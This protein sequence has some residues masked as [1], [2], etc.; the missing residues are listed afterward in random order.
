MA[1]MSN[2]MNESV[3]TH[4]FTPKEYQVELLDSAKAKNTIVCSSTSSS[5]AFIVVKLLQEYSWQMRVPYGK[6][7][8][9]I[10]DPQ[11]V[12]IMTCHVK[13]LTDL[14]CTSIEWNSEID[15][16]R[17]EQDF[18]KNQVIIS[19]AE[20]CVDVF[21]YENLL[22]DFSIFNL[23][24]VDDCLYGHRQSLIKLIMNKYKHLSSEK[25]PRI[26]GLTTGLL[27]S[28]LQPDRL[29][30]EL[31]RLEKLLDSHVDTS[32]EIVTLIRLS[33]RPHECII[34]CPGWEGHD[35]EEYIKTIVT[36]TIE[37][38][39]DHRFDP[40]EIYDDELL[41]EFKQVPDPRDVP[42]KLLNEFLEILED[43]GPWGADKAALHILSKIEKLKVKVPYER[44][45]L[46]LCITSTT[47]IS[48][49][50][51]CD[52]VFESYSDSLE[53]LHTFS[54]PKVL[55]FIQ[56]LKQ[57][58]PPGSKPEPNTNANTKE[59]TPEE[60]SITKN[61]GRSK[62]FRRPFAFQRPQSDDNLCALVFVH[63][64]YK[65]KALFT[66]LCTLSQSDDDLWWVSTLFSVEK[67]ADSVSEPREAENEH[68]TQEEVLR[69]F[70][71]HECNILITTS[72]LEQG[73]DLPKCNLVIR[74]D[75]PKSFH[76]YIQSK[77]RARAADAYYV[78][79]SNHSEVESFVNDLAEYNEVENILLRRCYSLE[80]DKEEE[81]V[82]DKYTELCVPYKPLE[83]KG[84]P[85]I[86]LLNSIP[87]LN[88]Y[89][90]KLPSDTFTKLTPI[91]KEERIDSSF[92][93][94]IRL[95]I[96]SPVKQTISSPPMPNCLLARRAAAFMV[97]QLLHKSSELD[98]YLQPI[99]KENFKATEE[100][101][102][103]FSLDDSEPDDE[104]T[105]IRPGTTKR[106]QYY[107]KRI[108]E[109]LLDCHPVPG[110]HT[111]FYE[112]VMI[113]T[114]PLPE[115]QNTRGRKIYPPE[116]SAQGF[117]ILTCKVIPKISAFPI[118]TRSGEVSVDLQL[119]SDDV[120]L[121]ETQ[122]KK[123]REFVNYTFTSVL[124]LQKYL[125]LFNPEASLNNYLIVPTIRRNDRIEVHWEFIDVIFDNLIVAPTFIP[126][127]QRTDYE[128]NEAEYSDAVVMPW[129]RNQDQPQYFYVAEICKNLN[130][131]SAFPG[132]EYATFEE[133]YKRKYGIQIQNIGQNLLDVDHTSARLNFL[134]PRYVNRKGVA[135]PTSS[136][137][138]KRAK[139]ENL[140]QKQIL[141]PELC[142]IHPFPASLW[143]KA[144]ALPCILYRINALLL[145]DQIR[146][147]VA[148]CLNLG[149]SDLPND[150]KWPSLNFGWSLSDVLK[151][152]REEELKKQQQ[153]KLPDE[154]IDDKTPN[155]STIKECKDGEL[156]VEPS[157]EEEDEETKWIEIGTW[158]N[159]MADDVGADG[160]G[161]GVRYASP[162]SW[163]PAEA[164]FDDFSD[165]ESDSFEDESESEWG[166]L[167]IE[168][169]GEH[170]AEALDDDDDDDDRQ[171]FRLYDD[172]NAWKIEEENELT[173]GLKKEFHEAC[174]RNKRKIYTRGIL[175]GAAGDFRKS[176]AKDDMTGSV[177]TVRIEEDVNFSLLHVDLQ[178]ELTNKLHCDNNEYVNDYDKSEELSFSFDKQPN[179]AEHPGPSP[180]V[181][182]QALTMS[183]AN[184][185]IN[186]ERLETI[187]DSF[188]KYAITNYLYS[189][190]E[191][192][193]EGKLSHLRSKQVSN[194]NLYRLGKRKSLGEFMIATKFDPHDNWLPPCFY[195]PKQLEE[196]LI[197]AQ[198]PA[199]CWSAAD[200]AAARSMTLDDICDMVRERGEEHGCALGLNVAA[201]AAVPY[202][203]VTQHSI[204]DK[205]IADCV[206]AVIGAYLIECGPRGA[207]LFMA[208]LGIRVLPKLSDSTYG[209]I[210]L[211]RSPLLR[212]IPDPEGELAR[213][214]DGYDAFEKNIGYKFRDRSYLLQAMTHASYYPN[215]LTDCY[216][217][218]EFLGDAVLDYLITRHLYEDPRMHSPGALTDLRSALVNNT[219]FASLAVRN[220]F[221]KYFR[222]LS[223]GLNEVVERFIRLQEESG[224]SLVDELYLVVETECEEVED[225]EVPKALG[226]VFES[227]AGAV[228][229]DSGMSLDAVWKVYYRMMKI[230]IEQ[231]SN[232]VP[233][234]PIRELLELEPETAKFG[235][236]EKLA[237]G[238]RVRVTVEVFGKGLFKGIGRNYRIAKC[239]AAKCALKHLK[240]RGLLKK[241]NEP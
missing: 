60:I 155:D 152:S 125:M 159:E 180:N 174:D 140:E 215:H 9:F 18:K 103:N 92:V 200:M 191:N 42:L 173:E 160:G 31:I 227:V 164:A 122:I 136:E 163:M 124:R 45:Y 197:D 67:V 51:A 21:M 17:I 181:L 230:E 231:F 55:K 142:A 52:N 110:K 34:E 190:Y 14:S 156:P 57:F 198:F 225:V 54:K 102:T 185:G 24:V 188:L 32:S 192:V 212:H 229:L 166:G 123:T 165:S 189:K 149:R 4:T 69:K 23:I 141:V 100:D 205:S 16:K 145:A 207:L 162:T 135:L 147:T 221:H 106:R 237:D 20:M 195:V 6:K 233:K 193:H 96:N 127:E 146:R 22:A 104:Y 216:Q 176:C 5:K 62:P 101:W 1:K 194:L 226:D 76:S 83:E 133:Y 8:L 170:Q 15:Y 219:I 139:R 80:P 132:S 238:R 111:Y 85:S 183:N 234:S 119:V 121:D 70:R 213:L 7:A 236:P 153:D 88:K 13:Y 59:P 79:F 40:S 35:L 184:D 223:P 97:C 169:T 50:A 178:V 113:L 204:P 33:C 134:T 12:P 175:V 217:R 158:R 235:K 28:E 68:K 201:A 186:L 161:G 144:V 131:M 65:A 71:C 209:E 44:H 116:E 151:K 3:Y 177:S 19:T 86:T 214:L 115:E 26:L 240:R 168:F 114:C 2:F 25:R 118:F 187:G 73:C 77:A 66:I 90:A 220:G 112:V 117:G 241:T 37:F 228:F 108:A 128:F 93:C 41:E 27:S 46:L 232:K 120:V 91:W 61:R 203:L 63:S 208:W 95:P 74:F 150:F 58:K 10:L 148:N 182:L 36:D 64:R 107:Y 224:H 78:L 210:Q 171:A 179:L 75:L 11:N 172:A 137:E 206:E 47:L 138:T 87:L 94:H 143:R 39:L 82:A 126:D 167:R 38:L 72:I 218:L 211:P 196:A 48:V 109:A 49:R 199:N 98:D 53:T 84:A 222:H 43:L 56:V 105:E 202:N 30:A 129:Y 89:C 157:T 29:E 81:M 99:N 239:T 130:P 154:P